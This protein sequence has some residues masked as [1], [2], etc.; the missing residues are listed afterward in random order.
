MAEA[1]LKPE[2]SETEPQ[3][4]VAAYQRY[5]E[6]VKTKLKETGDKI[7]VDTIKQAVDKAG[8]ELK[9]AGEHSAE[10]VKRLTVVLKKDIASTAEKLG[11][12]W[13]KLKDRAHHFFDIWQDR[14]TV[15]LG[16]AASAVG[17]WLHKKGDS[18][19][20]HI[21]MAGELTYGGTFECTACGKRIDIKKASYIQP[22]PEC[23]KSEFRR[24]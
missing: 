19:E 1:K 4:E 24:V 2:V 10:T 21:Y 6:S 8:D 12:K 11:P 20:H 13:E 7:H 22:C 23:L 15:F 9:E 3:Q 17:E 5:Y 16:H 14:S 18:M